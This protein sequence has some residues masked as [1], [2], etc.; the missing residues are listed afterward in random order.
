VNDIFRSK[1][2]DDD[3]EKIWARKG[4]GTKYKLD[5]ANLIQDLKDSKTSYVK[6]IAPNFESKRGNWVDSDVIRQLNGIGIEHYI[7][8][9]KQLYPL[10]VSYK[11]FCKRYMNLNKSDHR[12]FEDIDR[13]STNWEKVASCIL[14]SA[15]GVISLD[16]VAYGRSKIFLR[17][18]LVKELEELMDRDISRNTELKGRL[19]KMLEGMRFKKSVKNMA[20]IIRAR[21][22]R[23]DN[24]FKVW[25]YKTRDYPRFK[26]F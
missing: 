4:T 12:L 2:Y 1:T 11:Q 25:L 19:K 7:T 6:C 15:I 22:E 3:H 9:K 20:E 23:A 5:M 21:K 17:S 18:A 16:E 14:D 10:K 26:F 13:H 24:L 8:T